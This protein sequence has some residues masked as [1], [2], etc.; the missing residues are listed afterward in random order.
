MPDIFLGKFKASSN[1]TMY[2]H[3]HSNTAPFDKLNSCIAI[4]FNFS[5]T[6]LSLP[7]KN[8]AGTRQALKPNLKSIDAGWIKSSFI[9]SLL[10]IKFLLINSL[11]YWEANTPFFSLFKKPFY[12]PIIIMT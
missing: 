7:G 6:V 12:K 2:T 9:F 4:W 11:I 1:L 8:D 5:S 3:P 10:N